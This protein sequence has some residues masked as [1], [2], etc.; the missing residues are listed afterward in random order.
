[1]STALVLLD[2]LDGIFDLPV[3]LHGP[4][5]FLDVI[6]DLLERAR[7]AGA[8]VVHAQLKGPPGSRFGAGAPARRIHALASPRDRELVVNKEHP[9]AFQE[10]MLEEKLRASSVSR[11]VVAGFATEACVDT[12]VRSA[13]ARGFA[14]DLVSDGHTTTANAVLD[15]RTIILHHNAVLARFARVLAHTDVSF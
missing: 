2:V 10:T 5:H 7:R 8:L 15:A 11:L 4:E 9:D 6:V 1:M 14:V 12:T 13:Y 3:P